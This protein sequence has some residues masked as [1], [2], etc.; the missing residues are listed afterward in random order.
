MRRARPAGLPDFAHPPVVETVLSVQFE[1]LLLAK[2]AHFGLYWS[3]IRMG[4]PQT[5]EQAELPAVV[6]MEAGQPALPID[7]QLQTFNAPPTPRFW[8]TNSAGTELLQVQRDRFIKN[9]RK[10]GEQDVYPHY[11]Q[12][13]K[14]FDR[15]F[16][17]FS[18]FIEKHELGQVRI[19]QCEV[20]YINH[21][22]SGNGWNSHEDEDK[23]FN[24]WKQPESR[25]PGR[26]EGAAIRTKFPIRDI[27]GQ[28]CGRLH[29]S[30]QPVQRLSDGRP[31]FVM[32]LTAR[33]QS[34]DGTQF[35]DLGRKW[36]V[37]SF[38]ELTTPEM[39]RIWGRIQ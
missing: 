19:N 37:R 38:A 36:I 17:K 18:Q 3:Q 13:K 15:D 39:H 30:I 7:I 16:N 22:V 4:Y 35:F 28:F 1:Q 11:E 34:G 9:W 23:V 32:E 8:F 14:G 24:I 26:A 27:A 31:M 10:V 5:A 20:T 6:E 12:V 21:I 29:V 25:I 2:T 33:G